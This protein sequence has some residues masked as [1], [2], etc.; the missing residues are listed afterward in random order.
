M[1]GWFYYHTEAHYNGPYPTR[2][3]AVAAGQ[4][5]TDPT[6]PF[7]VVEG[8]KPPFAFPNADQVLAL[9]IE[10]NA[11]LGT[12]AEPF[13]VDNATLSDEQKQAL[14]IGVGDMISGWIASSGARFK[15][16]TFATMQNVEQIEPSAAG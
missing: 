11:D 13:D 1:F 16:S 5:M 8:K 12:E 15:V 6:L 2:A 3:D 7:W 14:A 9:F 10:I 4:A